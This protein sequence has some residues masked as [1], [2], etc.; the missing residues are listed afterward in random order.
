MKCSELRIKTNSTTDS[1]LLKGQITNNT[2][3]KWAIGAIFHL[4]SNLRKGNR[5]I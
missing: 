4:Q 2:S 3:V 5:G 1:L